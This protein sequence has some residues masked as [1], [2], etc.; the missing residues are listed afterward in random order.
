MLPPGVEQ[1][2][3]TESRMQSITASSEH[4][5]WSGTHLDSPYRKRRI[6]LS[7]LAYNMKGELSRRGEVWIVRP[8]SS[9][10]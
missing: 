3:G 10:P 4:D 9:R 5:L 1:P 6:S 7:E 2:K 8:T